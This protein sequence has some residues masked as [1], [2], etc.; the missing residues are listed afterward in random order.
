[1][2]IINMQTMRYINLLDK[3]SNVKTRSCFV[4]NGTIYFAVPKK[5]VSKAIGPEASNIRK[6]QD[7]LGKRVRVVS[8]C[9][10][11]LDIG[12][13]IEDVVAPI[14]FKSL[15]V[16]NGSVIITA[17]NHQN[18]ASLIGRNKRR[19][20]ELTSVVGNSFGMTIKII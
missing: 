6:M 19:L 12:R 7:K 11:P 3:A 17:G 18:K 4:Y 10:S 15:E 1:M 5:L 20:D 16:K 9:E 8:E 13:F 14:R 2:T